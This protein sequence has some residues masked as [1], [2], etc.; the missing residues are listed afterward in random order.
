MSKSLEK[1]ISVLI[2][3]LN[4]EANIAE[5]LAA[6]VR[7]AVKVSGEVILVDSLSSDRTV[8]IARRFPI[9][10]VQFSNVE[11][12][13]CGAAVQLGYQH[14]R[15]TYLYVL[16]GDMVLQ[17]GFLAIAMQYLEANP[18]VGGV[19][20]KLLDTSIKTA[21]DKRRANNSK[22]L[23]TIVEVSDLPGG[24]LYRRSAIDAV[25]YLAHRGL[26]ACEEAELGAR[27]RADGWRLVRLPDV[28]VLHTGHSEGNMI[29]LSRLWR[30]RRLH[31]YGGFLRSAIGHPW[32]WSSV[33]RVWHVFAPPAIHCAAV[34]L[35]IAA[36]TMGFLDLL[37]ALVISEALVWFIALLA[38][39]IKKKNVLDA[40]FS[41][42]EWH[43]YALA[44]IIGAVRPIPSP[45][46][47]VDGREITQEST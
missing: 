34:I 19:A 33:R 38:L 4:E 1:T 22:A 21:A 32:W 28:A 43:W 40:I 25:G 12:C 47:P 29:M 37:S 14:A 18:G 5:S 45:M 13:G 31:A 41:I 23:Q 10:I 30:N 15:G 16:D 44:A 8:A 2:K 24:G 20:G 26:A 11:D 3:A 42:V 9:R 46:T 7:E 35:G 6:A 36:A 39:S 17:P 27:I